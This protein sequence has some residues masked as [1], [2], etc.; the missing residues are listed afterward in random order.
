M[1]GLECYRKVECSK[2]DSSEAENQVLKWRTN[3][4]GN[5]AIHALEITPH[6]DHHGGSG[7]TY[8]EPFDPTWLVSFETQKMRNNEIFDQTGFV[9]FL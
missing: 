4:P 1:Y 7:I 6:L 8:N 9:P 3:R 5:A 2:T